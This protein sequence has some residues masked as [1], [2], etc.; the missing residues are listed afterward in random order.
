MRLGSLGNYAGLTQGNK[1]PDTKGGG[2]RA[3]IVRRAVVFSRRIEEFAVIKEARG[4]SGRG[5]EAAL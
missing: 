2:M 4:E 1:A 5:E 3:P